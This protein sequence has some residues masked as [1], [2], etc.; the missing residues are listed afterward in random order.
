MSP[1]ASP[2]G[3]IQRLYCGM[4][5]K[6]VAISVAKHG[7]SAKIQGKYGCGFYLTNQLKKT[8]VRARG[9]QYVVIADV[10]VGNTMPGHPDLVDVSPG[11]HSA[12]NSIIQPTVYVL[13]D[14]AQICPTHIL[15]YVSDV[16]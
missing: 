2:G 3:P 4:P 9:L 5:S 7:F 13:S 1:A 10:F 8:V 15:A 6:E 11:F 14:S 16:F 12:V